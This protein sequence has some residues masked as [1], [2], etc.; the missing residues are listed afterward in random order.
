MIES[1]SL[2][3]QTVSHY[4]II[5]KLGGGGMGVVYKAED[6]KLHRCVA[7]KLLPD[8]V[9]RDAHSLA[10]FQRE[11]QA[12]SA[13]NH[14]NIC[15]IYEIDEQNG[16]AF[17]VMEF[18][19]GQTLKHRIGGKPLPLEQVLDL[20]I[21][22]ADALDAAHR[23]GIIHRDIK[24][25]NIF[26][27]EHGHAKIL[28][29]GLAKL[30]LFGEGAGVSA[31]P[32]LTTEEALTSPGATV[33]TMAYMS[34]EQARGEELDVRTDLFSFGAVLYEMTTGRLAFPGSTSAIVLEAILNRAPPSVAR[35]NPDL[36][37]E[38]ERIIGK[39]LEKDRKLR[40]QSA[41]E[42]RT[43]LQRLKRDTESVK[44]AAV[45]LHRGRKRNLWLG[46]GVGALLIALA[47]S[48]WG[49]YRYFG[50]KPL[51]FQQIEITQLTT[52]G[53]V[54]NAAISPDGRYVAYTVAELR[55]GGRGGQSLWLRQLTGGDV[56][57]APPAD[58]R[59]TGLTYSH[60]GDFLYAVRSEGK[61]PVR[62]LY[63]MPAL[64]GAA[65]RLVADAG[66]NV[67]LSP[68]GKQFAFVR[69]FPTK[70]ES[71]LVVA[72]E[73]GSGEKML[74]VH[75][76]PEILTSVSWSP[77]G[78]TI[79][80]VKGSTES[81]VRTVTLVEVPVHGGSEHP[82]GRRRWGFI[83]DLAWVSDGRGLILD[84]AE[85]LAGLQQMAYLSYV[86]DEVR[87]I[88][89]D[90]NDYDGISSTVDTRI[91]ATV[92]WRQWFDVWVAPFTE[93]DGARPVTSDGHSRQATWGPDGRVIY[94]KVGGSGGLDIWVMDGDGTNPRQLT[95]NAG[96]RNR[97]PLV[98]SDGRYVVFASDRTGDM[99][100][101]R[102]DIDGNN[103]VQL[104]NSPLDGLWYNSLST[105]PDG[106]WVVYSKFDADRGI[107]K[108]PIE[109]GDPVRLNST[110]EA[111]YPAVS[112]DGDML[113]Y[114][115]RDQTLRPPIGVAIMWLDAS[116]PSKYFDISSAALRWAPDS[117]S[118][119]YVKDE[120]GVSNLWSQP[121]SGEPPKQITHFN[122]E[123]I[124]GFELSRDG[125][126][127]VMGRGTV[128]SDVVLIRDV[129]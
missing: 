125:K 3:G 129:R 102:M 97:A 13:L 38:L 7:L 41:A 121:I 78:E 104:T 43:D 70:S 96:Y 88:T 68:D 47:A 91:V 12:A 106:K 26:V 87:R 81:G 21:E 32:T 51:P 57:V 52:V 113:A 18:L 63:K 48:V 116:A 73:D 86:T 60:D 33:G 120:A 92:Q 84:S 2:L 37:T 55:P 49:I 85:Q 111:R 100:V 99:H 40:C 1:E 112:P 6:I 61:D 108:V 93:A 109:G 110:D 54:T 80:A 79:A 35:A 64:G 67:A 15:T 17:I 103:P 5:E 50:P 34:P 107:W 76:W 20:G 101:W 9:A 105:T 82:L 30:F 44:T 66:V 117:H 29:F 8:K 83:R 56:Q 53:K 19:D 74:V 65:K 69:Y 23:K 89:I 28:D 124:D 59:Y 122:N 31:L 90:P 114:F 98:T 22:I 39:A 126:R 36:P 27:T 71:A 10:R 25:A 115:Y 123:L 16:T 77:N 128:N 94:T 14:P 127:L 119:L 58:V 46:M 45:T 72:N 118:L 42:V 62:F 11:A 24:P 75:K 95:V 4:H